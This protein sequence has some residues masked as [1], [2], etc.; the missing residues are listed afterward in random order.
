MLCFCLSSV[1]CCCL[2]K[3]LVLS[4]QEPANF[5]S[6][7]IVNQKTTTS[8]TSD[9][10]S[11]LCRPDKLGSGAGCSREP[12]HNMPRCESEAGAKQKTQEEGQHAQPQIVEL[13][14]SEGNKASCK[15]CLHLGKQARDNMKM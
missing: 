9:P 14:E 4:C 3:P 11:I 7:E 1:L 8:T 6:E 5:P 10:L 2:L 13:K 12:L 15:K